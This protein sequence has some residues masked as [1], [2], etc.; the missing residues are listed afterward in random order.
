MTTPRPE[1]ADTGPVQPIQHTDGSIGFV[2]IE[3]RGGIGGAVRNNP[4]AS[5]L[6]T[7]L[8]TA[9][10]SIGAAIGVVKSTTAVAIPGAS[11]VQIENVL[12]EMKSITVKVDSLAGDM[13]SF[14][15]SDLAQR[16]RHTEDLLLKQESFNLELLERRRDWNE[17]RKSVELKMSGVK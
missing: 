6:V 4:E 3:V 7:A 14:K 2:P 9:I 15:E 11:S 1:N 16:V 12:A 8:T 5:V 10:L 17:W 13:R